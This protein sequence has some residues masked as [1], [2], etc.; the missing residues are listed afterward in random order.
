M[1]VADMSALA[2]EAANELANENGLTT[3]MAL[4]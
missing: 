4:R 3:K 1:R 2:E